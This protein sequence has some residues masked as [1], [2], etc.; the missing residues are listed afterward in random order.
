MFTTNQANYAAPSQYNTPDVPTT[1]KDVSDL[2]YNVLHSAL[3]HR[4]AEDTLTAALLPRQRSPPPHKPW[5]KYTPTFHTHISYKC[6]I[7]MSPSTTCPSTIMSQ[8]NRPFHKTLTTTSYLSAL[9]TRHVTPSQRSIASLACKFWTTPN[10]PLHEYVI[11][12]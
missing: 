9:W 4:V 11:A 2:I 3:N 1:I 8:L 10:H 12:G 5:P 7:T 6:R